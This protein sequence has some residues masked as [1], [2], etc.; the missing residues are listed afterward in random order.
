MI[1]FILNSF[2]EYSIISR[3]RYSCVLVAFEIALINNEKIVGLR[4]KPCKSP[5]I[6]TKV[7]VE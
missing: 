4:M 2:A 1:L 7:I 3:K 5:D 6:V